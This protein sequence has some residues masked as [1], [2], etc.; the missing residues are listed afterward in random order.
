MQ[1]IIENKPLFTYLDV[2]YK[3][4][5]LIRAINKVLQEVNYVHY[6]GKLKISWTMFNEIE[7]FLQIDSTFVLL[8]TS[9]PDCMNITLKIMNILENI[10]KIDCNMCNKSCLRFN[11]FDLN[12]EDDYNSYKSITTHDKIIL[13]TL[14][15]VDNLCNGCHKLFKIYDNIDTSDKC[16]ICMEYLNCDLTTFKCRIHNVH[17]KCLHEYNNNKKDHYSCPFR[18]VN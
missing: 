8:L 15:D 5:F 14:I 9:K 17:I 6:F 7:V 18:C 4:Q 3:T 16:S 1:F 2:N 11:N 12:Y 10:D 13:K